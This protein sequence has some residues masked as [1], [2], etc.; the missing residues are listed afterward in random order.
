LRFLVQKERDYSEE[1]QRHP[2][3]GSIP[4]ERT[5]FFHCCQRGRDNHIDVI[6]MTIDEEKFHVYMLPSMICVDINVGIAINA[7]GG[8]YWIMLSLMPKN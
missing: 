6:E 7:K 1:D 3:R 2:G 8:Y 5:T 4:K